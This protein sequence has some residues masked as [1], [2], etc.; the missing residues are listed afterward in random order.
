M[1]RRVG[2]DP[3]PPT[4]STCRTPT[5]STT[6]RAPRSVAPIREWLAQHDILLA[7]PLQRVGVLQLRPRVPRRPARRRDGEGAL[8]LD[9]ARSAESGGPADDRRRPSALL[10]PRDAPTTCCA[11]STTPSV[12]VGVLLAPF[13]SDRLLAA[14]SPPRCARPT[15]ISAASCAATRPPG[16]VR[17]GQPGA[18]RAPPT[19]SSAR[20]T[21]CGLRGLKM[22]PTRLVS[23]T[24]TSRTGSTHGAAALELPIL[25]HSGIFIDGRSG[26]F[27]RPAVLRGGARA[28]GP[29]RHARA[30]RLAVVRR[31]ERRRPDRPHQRRRRR[32]ACQFRFDISFGA[33]PIYRTRGAAQRALAVLAPGAAAVRQRLLPALRGSDIR[34]AVDEVEALLDALSVTVAGRRRIFGGTAAAWLGRGDD[35]HRSA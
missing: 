19:I 14:R 28:P 4:R 16:R 2:P 26:R 24:T 6:T 11:R 31:G 12:D 32:I 30:S 22:V 10:R 18:R 8:D 5:W 17:R 20:S 1:L 3:A 33:P 15:S 35:E 21:T 27:C 23:R 7:G 13:L 34:A 25:F 29:A 9:A